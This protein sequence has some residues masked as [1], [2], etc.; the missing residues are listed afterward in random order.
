V[1]P[2][3]RTCGSRLLF[4]LADSDHAIPLDTLRTAHEGFFPALMDQ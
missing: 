1:Q 4:E 2:I 3:G